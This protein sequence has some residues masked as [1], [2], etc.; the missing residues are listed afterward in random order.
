MAGYIQLSRGLD[1]GK[2][3]QVLPP[4]EA[5]KGAQ[6]ALTAAAV[7]GI[8]LWK[9]LGF[10]MAL[11]AGIILVFTL[12]QKI[13]SMADAIKIHPLASLGW[14]ALILFATP[15]AA[16]IVC[17]TVIGLPVGLISLALYG[18]ALYLCQIPVALCIGRLIFRHREVDS[19]GMLVGTLATGL[20]ILTLVGLIPVVDF[21]V[22]LGIA[23]FGLGSLV[24]SQ[25]KLKAESR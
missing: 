8:V 25:I 1:R 16:I 21:I 24:A 4:P 11:L 5:R 13:T 12:R 20:V 9:F 15:I 7:A 22:G 6:K 14:G 10:L 18:I 17:C 23:L 2:V 3:T 19:G